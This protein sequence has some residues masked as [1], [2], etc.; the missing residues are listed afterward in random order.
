MKQIHYGSIIH[1]IDANG[2]RL[3]SRAVKRELNFQN[4]RNH[5][6]RTKL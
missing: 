4:S 3:Y 5:E 1:S 6:R 2:K